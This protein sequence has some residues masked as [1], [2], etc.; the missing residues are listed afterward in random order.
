VTFEDANL[1]AAVRD[2]LEGAGQQADFT[3]RGVVG[4]TTIVANQRRISSIVGIQN[5][6]SLEH[7][8]VS[9]NSIS[10]ISPLSGLTSLTFLC[11]GANSIT[12][13]S[14][15]SGLTNL[16]RLRRNG[17]SITDISALSGLIPLGGLFLDDNPNL[18]NIQP[19][20]DNIGLGAG[21]LVSLGGTSVS[22][23]DVAALEA[24]GVTVVS[25][26]P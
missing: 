17:N 9:S 22:C 11:L 21:D 26:C 14:A 18:S 2:Y 25:D 10:D 3:C 19:L 8:E 16:G 24:K 6:T 1:E 20:L 12:D 5:C 23:T 13:V 7:F 4:V 15:L